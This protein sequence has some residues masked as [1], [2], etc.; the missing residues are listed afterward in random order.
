MIAAITSARL[1]CLGIKLLIMHGHC[2]T[3]CVS[4][5]RG[6][7]SRFNLQNRCSRYYLVGV[8]AGGTSCP[9][10]VRHCKTM[11]PCSDPKACQLP[12]YCTL[13]QGAIDYVSKRARS[14][15]GRPCVA[16]G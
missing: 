10:T 8:T 3:E 1:Y 2:Q 7:K 9:D 6:L 14:T 11:F 5:S 13:M 4:G 15:Y 16:K 12:R